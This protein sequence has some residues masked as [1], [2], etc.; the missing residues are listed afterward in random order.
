MEKKDA[1]PVAVK[2]STPVK[3]K[4]ENNEAVYYKNAIKCIQ[5]LAKGWGEDATYYLFLA[6]IQLNRMTP[7][8]R[9][10]VV[11]SLSTLTRQVNGE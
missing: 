6:R 11:N 2:V 3:T 9:E 10:K 4:A 8:Q 5:A 7:Q 1:L